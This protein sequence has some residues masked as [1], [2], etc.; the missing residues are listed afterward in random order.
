MRRRAEE[1][2]RGPQTGM[3]PAF[4]SLG[5]INENGEPYP[6]HCCKPVWLLRSRPDQVPGDSMRGDPPS[7]LVY[8]R[9]ADFAKIHI[10]KDPS[11]K[12]LSSGGVGPSEVLLLADLLC[13][14]SAARLSHGKPLPTAARPSSDVHWQRQLPSFIRCSP[15]A[16]AS[17]FQRLR[18]GR[19]F[20]LFRSNHERNPSRERRQL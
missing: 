12:N 14:V 18:T 5:G 6:R 19:Q 8:R 9:P 11:Q 4:G 7:P 15:S 1:R 10:E 3:S 16:P 2:R 17:L 13:G 20:R